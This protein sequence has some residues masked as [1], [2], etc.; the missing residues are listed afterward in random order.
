MGAHL[1]ANKKKNIP[2]HYNQNIERSLATIAL[3]NLD[4]VCQPP[5]SRLYVALFGHIFI[6]STMISLTA[7]PLRNE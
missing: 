7:V 6:H 5:L 2:L 4:I 1:W 3:R